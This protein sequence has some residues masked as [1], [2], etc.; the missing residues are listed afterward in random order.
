MAAR[1]PKPPKPFDIVEAVWEDATGGTNDTHATISDAI[2]AYR[3]CLRIVCGYFVGYGERDGRRA[4]LVGTDNDRSEGNEEAI[5]GISTI[6]E[7]MVLS[8]EIV[9]PD[10]VKKSDVR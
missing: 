5:G 9:R 8:I 4:L 1:K 7:H 6:P 3:P 10:G 2:K